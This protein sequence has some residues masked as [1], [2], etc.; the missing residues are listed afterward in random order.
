LAKIEVIQLDEQEQL[1]IVPES[2]N[3]TH[4]LVTQVKPATLSLPSWR[5]AFSVTFAIPSDLSVQ[6]LLDF[7][8]DFDVSLMD[9][10]AMAFYRSTGA[11]VHLRLMSL[12]FY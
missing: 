11:E 6:A 10:V 5:C 7:S 9:K 8:R 4:H 2:H 3:V 1:V 12:T